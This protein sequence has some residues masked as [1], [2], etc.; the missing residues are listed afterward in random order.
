[1]PACDEAKAAWS[2]GGSF[3]TFG[4]ELEHNDAYADV[5]RVAARHRWL[6]AC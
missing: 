6:A 2:T 4:D 1:M 5:E 3:P